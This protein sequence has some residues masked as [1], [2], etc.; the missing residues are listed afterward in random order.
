MEE[1]VIARRAAGNIAP[2]KSRYEYNQA[3]RLEKNG[4]NFEYEKHKIEWYQEI[5]R[6]HC[7]VC[8]STDVCQVRSYTPDFYFPE[9]NIY[10]ETKGRFTSENRTFMSQIVKQADTEIR[11]VFMADNYCTK[12]KGMK[13]SRWCELNNIEYA[14]GSIPLEWIEAD[15]NDKTD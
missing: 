9:T 12:K 14:I 8:Q 2:Y 1:D 5:S 6:G 3:V 10:V 15:V 7:P 4:V 11:M 13:Y